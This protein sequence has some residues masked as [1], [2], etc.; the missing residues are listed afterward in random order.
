MSH[1]QAVLRLP[2]LKAAGTPQLEA[3]RKQLLGPAGT[4]PAASPQMEPGCSF[5]CTAYTHPVEP[6]T[7]KQIIEDTKNT[8][9]HKKTQYCSQDHLLGET[10][11]ML[12]IANRLADGANLTKSYS[13][14]DSKRLSLA[15]LQH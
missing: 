9:I 2:L 13:L 6:N 4:P 7:L 12:S 15:Q 8:R 1:A 3:A 11:C 14:V 10:V 5:A